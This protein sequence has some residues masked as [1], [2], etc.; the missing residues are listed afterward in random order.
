V[1][2]TN[3]SDKGELSRVDEGVGTEGAERDLDA[4]TTRLGWVKVA[5]TVVVSGKPSKDDAEA[6]WNLGATV[7]AHLMG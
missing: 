1:T 7:A 6:C 4:I 2:T 5:D 3:N